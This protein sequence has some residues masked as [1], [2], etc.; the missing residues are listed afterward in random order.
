MRI[1]NGFAEAKEALSRGAHPQSVNVAPGL[2]VESID[3]LSAMAVPAP[4]LIAVSVE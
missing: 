2:E 1:I 3:F 4:F